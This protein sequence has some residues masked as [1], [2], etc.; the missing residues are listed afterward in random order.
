LRVRE[1]RQGKRD[2]GGNERRCLHYGSRCGSCQLWPW[3]GTED[4]RD[5][6]V[7]TVAA[8]ALYP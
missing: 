7:K 4:N 2:E 3:S 6:A 5:G 8:V 1:A